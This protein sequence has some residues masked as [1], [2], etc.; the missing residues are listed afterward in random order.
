MTRD[1]YAQQ[2][3]LGERSLLDLLDSENELFSSSL[4]LV[5]SSANEIAAAYRLLAL[6]GELIDS[7]QIS[8]N[9]FSKPGYGD[10]NNIGDWTSSGPIISQPRVVEVATEPE[11]F[12]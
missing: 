7:L 1:M 10:L 3:V 11:V 12:E 2:F 6:D 5:T 9:S 8:R 4:M